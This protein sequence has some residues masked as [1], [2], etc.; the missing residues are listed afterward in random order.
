M[1]KIGVKVRENVKKFQATYWPVPQLLHLSFSLVNLSSDSKHHSTLNPHTRS[2]VDPAFQH[3]S[4]FNICRDLLLDQILHPSSLATMQTFRT[5]RHLSNGQI[6]RP[7]IRQA[8]YST[9]KALVYRS[10]GNVKLEERPI[11]KISQP[12]D[13]IVKLTKSTICGTD[14]HIK[15]GDVATCEE[16]TILGHEGVGIVH[17]A[18]ES[19]RGFKKGEHVLIS[20]ICSCATCEY[21]RKG[22]Y[23]HCTT[24]GKILLFWDLLID[25]CRLDPWKYDRWHSSRIRTN[26]SCRFLPL[27]NTR[28]S[29]R[30]C[31]GDAE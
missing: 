25:I 5:V 8:F 11:P 18:G 30:S 15:Q 9:M 1:V 6:F 20:C 24:G 23:S 21:C 28:R 4:I 12:T 31:I 3:A 7:P 16:G 17:E 14:L 27:P 22:M 19:V 26:P 29:R 10:V 13:A 2:S